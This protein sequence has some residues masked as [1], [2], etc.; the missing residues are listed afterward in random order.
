MDG[1]RVSTGT[2]DARE[3]L[4]CDGNLAV[5]PSKKVSFDFGGGGGGVTEGGEGKGEKDSGSIGA[6]PEMWLRTK[7]VEEGGGRVRDRQR[8]PGG[9]YFSPAGQ[10]VALG[11]DFIGGICPVSARLACGKSPAHLV[12]GA[13]IFAG[14]PPYFLN[15]GPLPLLL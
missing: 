1:R 13:S 15:R 10:P 9:S 11:L 8:D 14:P 12:Q 3:G 4:F 2:R 6:D 5:R 7:V